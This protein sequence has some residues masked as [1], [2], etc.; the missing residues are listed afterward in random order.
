M[1][2]IIGLP[3]AA[4]SFI[5]VGR[6][7]RGW[8]VTLVTPRPPARALSTRLA[9]FGNYQSAKAHAEATGLGMQRPVRLPSKANRPPRGHSGERSRSSNTKTREFRDG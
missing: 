9:K 7:G 2:Q 1:A 8:A 4:K 3:T 6:A 5:R